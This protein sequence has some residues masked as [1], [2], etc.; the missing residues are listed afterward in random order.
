[1]GGI[2]RPEKG[3]SLALS[4][5][6]YHSLLLGRDDWSGPHAKCTEVVPY[7][8]PTMYHY[9]LATATLL[10]ITP[11][12]TCCTEHV[13]YVVVCATYSVP[14][15]RYYTYQHGSITNY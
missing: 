7:G 2:P 6:A 9:Q 4:G 3:E 10:R 11:Y 8:A 13:T 14:V 15:L 12:H 5:L 1:M